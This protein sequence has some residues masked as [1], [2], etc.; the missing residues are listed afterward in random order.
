MRFSILLITLF[1]LTGCMNTKKM[2]LCDVLSQRAKNECRYID[3]DIEDCL[4]IKKIAEEC[5]DRTLYERLNK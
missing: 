5:K 1:I 4:R 3:R 2:T